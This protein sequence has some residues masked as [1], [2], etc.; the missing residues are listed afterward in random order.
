VSWQIGFIDLA[1][2][3]LDV[4]HELQDMPGSFFIG[5]K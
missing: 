1:L 3:F 2:E 4:P 5:L